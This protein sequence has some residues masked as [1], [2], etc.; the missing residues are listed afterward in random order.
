M[1]SVVYFGAHG[2]EF[3]SQVASWQRA[4][5]QA[6]KVA[7]TKARPFP[8]VIKDDLGRVIHEIKG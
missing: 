7:L 8:I 4:M 1:Y 5:D 3:S 6:S 2:R